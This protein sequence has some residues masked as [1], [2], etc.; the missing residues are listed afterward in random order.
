M[1]GVVLDPA[2]N[3]VAGV[4]VTS[5]TGQTTQ[6]GADG[7]W[8]LDVP[9]GRDYFMRFNGNFVGQ[10]ATTLVTHE[11]GGTVVAT[12]VFQP[13]DAGAPNTEMAAASQTQGIKLFV[14]GT[15]MYPAIVV[16]PLE[17]DIPLQPAP[18]GVQIFVT[19]LQD[20]SAELPGNL[21]SSGDSEDQILG[22]LASWDLTATGELQEL[23]TF[24][25]DLGV[26]W[27]GR[28][29]ELHRHDPAT[30][31]WDPTRSREQKDVGAD[32]RV[33]FLVTVGTYVVT[34]AGVTYS[35]KVKP[36][37]GQ[38]AKPREELPDTGGETVR[39]SRPWTSL[40]DSG[41]WEA[42]S[43]LPIDTLARM[44]WQLDGGQQL[45]LGPPDELQTHT[46][47]FDYNTA[48]SKHC[49]DKGGA[50]KVYLLKWPNATVEFEIW[51]GI[52]GAG[53]PYETVVSY[54]LMKLK[55]G[56]VTH[57]TGGGTSFGG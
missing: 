27:G 14:S 25:V 38:E 15:N 45:S 57:T 9:Y 12:Q 49:K 56:C 41:D 55:G 16:S 30:G 13:I 28:R 24:T 29:V 40:W 36:K 50:S 5:P 43:G 6:T 8:R 32:G 17:V 20:S 7:V 3:G 31:F 1:T 42:K 22:P 44:V 23:V 11:E 39:A 47:T 26:A 4:Q 37:N 48:L 34:E 19:N 35:A 51:G 10:V 33:S 46:F 18:P 54:L 53:D 52:I 21:R 2:G